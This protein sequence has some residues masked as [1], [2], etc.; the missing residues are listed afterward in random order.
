MN[1]NFPSIVIA[2]FTISAVFAVEWGQPHV[3]FWS[4]YPIPV[5]VCNIT[6][7]DNGTAEYVFLCHDDD[8]NLDL[9]SYPDDPRVIL[10]FDECGEISGVRACYIKTDIPKRA[11]SR[12]VAFNYSYHEKGIYRNH[13]YWGIDVLCADTLFASPETLAA[14][15][16]STE[17][18]DLYVILE[19]YVFTKLARS[20]SDIEKQG[21]TKQGCLDGMG[22]H[23]FYKM[24]TD[25]PC[26]E[27]VG[28]TALYDHGE[29][30]GVVQ[31]PFGAFTSYKR[32]WFE[33]PDVTISKMASPNAPECL[34]D[35]IPYYGIT[36]IHIF[37]KKNPRETYCP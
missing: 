30:I 21:F 35:L 37:M 22:Q 25:T 10:L 3:T 36:S 29:L 9:Y 28:V 2:T 27:L 20:E 17:V 1:F 8:F 16:R 4:Y 31:I 13:T 24:Y 11:E 12:G 15:C 26:D 34:Y 19:D 32:V 5:S 7:Y 23:Y 14:G 33:D 18:S 6:S